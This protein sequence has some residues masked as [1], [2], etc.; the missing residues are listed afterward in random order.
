M[1]N[2]KYLILALLFCFSA[3]EKTVENFDIEKPDPKLVILEYAYSDSFPSLYVSRNI[4][5]EEAVKPYPI[6]NANCKL[7]ENNTLLGELSIGKDGWY[8]SKEIKFSASNNY[9]YEVSANGCPTVK[10]EFI[11]APKPEIISVDTLT[12]WEKSPDCFG[13][14]I[15]P[16]LK[17]DIDFKNKP[18]TED[19]FL[20]E[21]NTY[22]YQYT[23][24][25]YTGKLVD[26]NLTKNT[27]EMMSD[28]PYIESVKQ[29]YEDIYYNPSQD[30][31]KSG[32]MY[33][34]SDKYLNNGTNQ[35]TVKMNYY[36]F[37]YGE[38]SSRSENAKIVY[39]HFIAID[40]NMYE[41]ALSKGRNL[42]A[43]GNP[44]VEPVTI[45]SNI[46]NG[47]GLV[48]GYSP[49]EYSIDISGIIQNLYS[50]DNPY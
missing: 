49:V 12:V 34:F 44:F 35:L 48:S 43:E 6:A 47:L 32:T 29:Y 38:N 19:Y 30:E 14:S 41:Y 27:I 50:I 20:V 40:K 17:V 24:D 21:F 25:Q 16:Y 37:F 26:S 33:I 13:C 23:Y 18:D 5:L 46:E 11:V 4:S 28:A 36:S 2:F 31:S 39:M 22:S 9:R 7:F 8:T 1:K 15:V 3:C 45:Y 10:S 42:A